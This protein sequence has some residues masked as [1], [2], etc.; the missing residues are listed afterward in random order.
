MVKPKSLYNRFVFKNDDKG[1][2]VRACSGCGYAIE[3]CVRT[4]N[5]TLC[6]LCARADKEVKLELRQVTT[7][8]TFAVTRVHL[9]PSLGED[10]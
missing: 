8:P 3:D 6:P 7:W 2:F 5:F 9:H 4:G 1:Y 10:T